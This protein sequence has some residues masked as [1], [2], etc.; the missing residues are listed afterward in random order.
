MKNMLFL[1]LAVMVS[2]ALYAQPCTPAGD[3]TSYGTGDTWIGY[4]YDNIN[5][6]S[7][8]G[9]VNEGSAGNPGFNETFGGDNV[10]YATNGCPVYTET[11]SVRYKLKKTFLSGNYQV[12][13]GGDDGFRLSFD[14][15]ATW[16]IDRWWDQGYTTTTYSG[17]FSG[18]YDMVLE[19][20]ENG[21][22]NRVSFKVDTVCV[23]TED[24]SV[25]GTGNVWKGY[26]YTGMNFNSYS[27]LVTEGTA[28]NA[29]FDENFGG[30][31]TTY[32]TSACGVL[33]E[34]FSAQ[35]RLQKTFAAG[36]YS[37]IMGG[38]DGYRLSL[39]GGATWVINNW[40]DQ[41]YNTASYS[42]FLSGT[43]NM[44]IE[45]Y[46]NGG[47]NR[48]SFAMSFLLPVQLVNFDG[49][50]TNKNIGLNWKVSKE[51]NT[52]YYLVERSVNGIDFTN[53]GKVYTGSTLIA[54]GTDKI[55][56]F[57]DPSPA[58]GSNY[59][60]L[61][62]VDK[63]GKYSYSPVIKIQFEEKKTGFIFRSVVSHTPVYLKTSAEIKNGVVELFEMS[64]KKLQEIKLPSLVAAGQT[65]TLPLPG[66]PA[67]GYVLICKSGGAIKAK[68]IIVVR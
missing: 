15:G 45:F 13:V 55:Y 14:G 50:A 66:T 38:D 63:D 51:T 5:F 9:Y 44:V 39:D 36:N 29:D 40:W 18:T 67:G 12:T 37:F 21:G 22:G 23:G 49:K 68:Q 35:Y 59:Y 56:G 60:R 6:T 42:G 16:L 24:Q 58:N 53:Q 48:L 65:I 31:N 57:T 2:S 47:S 7:Y 11:F 61:R 27:G 46:E 19:Y 25:Y 26:I 17:S 32:S 3:E 52:D 64:G 43:V 62:M 10:N 30:D 8:A 1:L 28:A 54:A 41:S 4:V 20:Y 33:T 34:Q